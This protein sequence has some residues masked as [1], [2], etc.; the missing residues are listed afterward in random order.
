MFPSNTGPVDRGTGHIVFR[1]KSW[2]RSVS[3]GRGPPSARVTGGGASALQRIRGRRQLVVTQPT[4]LRR[5]PTSEVSAYSIADFHGSAPRGDQPAACRA[6]PARARP[7]RTPLP[8]APDPRDRCRDADVFAAP[9]PARRRRD[10]ADQLRRAPAPRAASQRGGAVGPPAADRRRRRATG[11][12]PPA[13]ALRQGLPRA[14][15]D[16]PG[17]YRGEAGWILLVSRARA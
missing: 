4:P 6:V 15:R 8:E 5:R 1:L 12:I 14:L 10:R 3:V 13:V 2:R 7:G 9:A 17:A 11:R 16:P